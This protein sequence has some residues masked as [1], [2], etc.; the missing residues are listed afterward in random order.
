M[1]KQ[2]R[3]CLHLSARNLYLRVLPGQ[4]GSTVSEERKK[5]T[6]KAQ[7][8]SLGQR[9]NS[10]YAPGLANPPRET[11]IIARVYVKTH[12]SI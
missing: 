10:Y 6:I 12:L 1:R 5:T 2:I 11:R 4:K 3:I 7:K 9:A 8:N